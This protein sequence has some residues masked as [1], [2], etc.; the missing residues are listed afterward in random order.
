MP[1]GPAERGPGGPAEEPPLSEPARQALG[2]AQGEARAR[3]ADRVEPEHV[4]L[5]LVGDEQSLAARLLGRLGAPPSAIRAELMRMTGGG[6]DRPEDV[7]G[8]VGSTPPSFSAWLG[9]ALTAASAEATADG[10][11]IE[12]TDFLVA[13]TV[14]GRSPAGW[15]LAELGVDGAGVRASAE[16]LRLLDREIARVGREMQAAAADHELD[17]AAEL[18]AQRRQL[19]ARRQRQAPPDAPDAD[20]ADEP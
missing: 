12:V 7:E 1:D 6:D 19:V 17:R 5:G 10:R 8:E 18:R 9:A 3:G 11:S 15:V 4:L 20:A 2:R 14:D 16:H 13:M